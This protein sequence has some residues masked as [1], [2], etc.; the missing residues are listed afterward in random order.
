MEPTAVSSSSSLVSD[1]SSHSVPPDA[2]QVVDASYLASPL[3]NSSPLPPRKGSSAAQSGLE[4]LFIITGH[5]IVPFFEDLFDVLSVQS[6]M[7][8]AASMFPAWEHLVKYP[9]LVIDD[10]HLFDDA[11]QEMLKESWPA[12]L[13]EARKAAPDLSPPQLFT[14]VCDALA[15]QLL[16]E[17]NELFGNGE[18]LNYSV[19]RDLAGALL[20]SSAAITG[21][22]TDL[23]DLPPSSAIGTP[24]GRRVALAAALEAAGLELRSDSVMCSNYIADEDGA[25]LDKCIDSMRAT[26]T[27][28]V[29]DADGPYS[30][31]DVIAWLVEV[32]AEMKWLFSSEWARE[33]YRSIVK[34]KSLYE[35][36]FDEHATYFV[37]ASRAAKLLVV[38]MYIAHEKGSRAG[39]PPSLLRD[40]DRAGVENVTM[41]RIECGVKRNNYRGGRWGGGGG[42]AC[43][44][45]GEYGHFA[46]DCGDFEEFDDEFEGSD[47]DDY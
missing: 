34:E 7:K 4:D 1:T 11:N 5:S 36:A 39:I 15:E 20:A 3:D 21:G 9:V 38:K 43:F 17:D 8:E 30:D 18:Q 25:T 26:S 41:E 19:F 27:P 10:I 40:L 35:D 24:E 12:A 45:C 2:G 46:R 37:K 32:M 44:R 13:A 14:T 47:D 29:T 16:D 28:Y 6:V 31:A 33:W 42:G 23:S 22:I